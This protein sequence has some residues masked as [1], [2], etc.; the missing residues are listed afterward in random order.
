[1]TTLATFL[2]GVRYDVTD[3]ETGLEFDDR[4][5]INYLNR[6]IVLVDSTLNSIRSDELFGAEENID[7]AAD[8]NYLN[9]S[10]L[11]N[12]HWDSIN[13]V[14]IDTDK[15][16]HISVEE[17]YNKR[18]WYSSD[19]DP[20]KFWALQ[21]NHILFEANAD[22]AETGV[23][24]HY[25]KRTR[26]L[27]QSWSDTFTAATT[28]ICTV[29]PAHTFVTGD[30]RFQVSNSGGALPTGLSASTDY[31][32]EFISPTTFYL[33]TTK[34]NSVGSSN[35]DITD[36]GTGTHTITHTEYMPFEGKY[37][38][39]FREMLVLHAKAK[40]EGQL[41]N[42]DSIF[43]EIFRKRAFEEHIRRSY[44]PPIYYIDF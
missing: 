7:I 8:Q 15:L 35:I 4:E 29:S 37:D 13:A 2:E 6:M 25:R 36:A 9:I 28:D 14:W 27:L 34:S 23:E 39:L 41:S 19:V 42:P 21:G 43:Q 31:W 26:P 18:M 24:I 3:Y 33:C 16:T 12:G 5:L 17:M 38:N 22:N 10:D 30:G 20:P 44:V 32:M 1:M 40:K 11:N